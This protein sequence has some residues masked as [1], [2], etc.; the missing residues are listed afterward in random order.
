M[1]FNQLKKFI[2]ILVMLVSPLVAFGEANMQALFEK[3]NTSYSK[4]QYKEA[5]AAYQQV[6]NAGYQST[7]LYYNMGNAEYKLGE[8]PSA[9]LYYEKAH[10]LAPADEDI[11]VNLR[12]ANLR[13]TD[14]IDETPEFFLNK[15]WNGFI[16]SFSVNVLALISILLVLMA[17]GLLIVY[18]FTNSVSIK[19]GAF[20]VSMSLF[21]IG[22]VIVSLAGSQVSYFNGH[23]QGIIFTSTVNVKSG[24]IDQSNTL[25]VLHEGTKVNLLDN[26]NG[27][28][29]IKLANGNVGWVRVADA[30]EI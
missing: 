27:W 7:A 6:I 1:K 16:L 10:K 23:K 9:L 5:V 24:P 25:F 29:K 14:K 17:S 12:F 11:N 26:T 2:Y 13:T 18:F 30:K 22:I 15:W 4:G 28:V 20:Y 8:V 21:F 19:K 3:G